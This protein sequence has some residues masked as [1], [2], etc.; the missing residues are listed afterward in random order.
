MKETKSTYTAPS[1]SIL[2]FEATDVM[3]LSFGFDDNEGSW[4][5]LATPHEI[6]ENV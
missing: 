5:P 4:M 1:L 2:V 6:F 3:G